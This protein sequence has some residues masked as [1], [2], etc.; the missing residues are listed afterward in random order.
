MRTPFTGQRV[1]STNFRSN[2]QRHREEALRR[3][4]FEASDILRRP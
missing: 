1:V 2:T 4:E 3:G